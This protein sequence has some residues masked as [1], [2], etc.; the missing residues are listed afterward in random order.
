MKTLSIFIIALF[1]C[2]TSFAQ[3]SQKI[4]ETIKGKV[5]NAT[6]NESVSYTNIGLAGTYIGTASNVEGDFELKIT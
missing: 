6:T 2:I 5:V 1:F 3:Q 4:V